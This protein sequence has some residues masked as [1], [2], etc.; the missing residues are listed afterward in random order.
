MHVVGLGLIDL[1]EPEVLVTFRDELFPVVGSVIPLA[2]L[3][4]HS[5]LR[6]V[7]GR[8]QVILIDIVSLLLKPEKN[9]YDH[10]KEHYKYD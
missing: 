8:I 4:R 6:P 9:I 1:T 5:E 7:G 10:H 3:Y 2:R